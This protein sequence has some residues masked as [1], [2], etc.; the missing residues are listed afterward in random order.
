MTASMS[1]VVTGAAGTIGRAIAE[2]LSQQGWSVVGVDLVKFPSDLDRILMLEGDI[3]TPEVHAHAAILAAT[4][5]PLRGWVNCAG[6]NIL[7]SVTEVSQ[8]ALR[9]GVDVNLLGTFYGVAAAAKAMLANTSGPVQGSIVNISSI[10]ASVGFPGFAAYA[11]TKGGIEALTRQVAAEYVGQGI[12]CN[13][14]SP[15]LITSDMNEKLLASSPDADAIRSRWRAITPI[16][17]WGTGADVAAAVAFLLSDDA[18][19]ITGEMLPVNGGAL[20]VAPG[21]APQ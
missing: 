2:R 3:A 10:Q 20:T 7:G 18:A 14:V 4:H 1:C 17:R 19:F 6:Y 12:R 5:A 9:R 16:G 13:T 15:G 8:A 11:M 21:Q